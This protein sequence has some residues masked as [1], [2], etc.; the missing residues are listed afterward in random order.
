ML[1]LA[2]A[3]PSRAEWGDH[4]SLD[5]PYLPSQWP[6]EN[7]GQE[8]WPVGC[9]AGTS[10][11]YG[12]PGA[13]LEWGLAFDAGVTGAGAVIALGTPGGVASLYCED[14]DIAPR[15]WTNPGEIAGNGVDD[16]MNG[17][18]DDVNGWNFASNSGVV[19]RSGAPSGSAWHDTQVAQIAVGESGN[20]FGGAG[21]A[22][23][24]RILVVVWSADENNRVFYDQVLPYATARGA[25]VVLVPYTGYA[26]EPSGTQTPEQA[27][28][29]VAQAPPGTDRDAILASSAAVVIWGQPDRPTPGSTGYQY[30]ACDPSALGVV[31]S[32]QN[33]LSYALADSPFTDVALPGALPT[34]S[35]IASSW[36]MGHAAGV[37]ALVLEQSPWLTRSQLVDRLLD[38]AEK[39]GGYPY[40]GGRNDWYGEGRANAIRSLLLGDLDMDGVA[41]DGNGSGVTGDLPCAGSAVGCDDN[42]PFEPNAAQVDGGGVGG[43]GADGTGNACQ[44]GDVLGDGQ[45]LASDVA[46]VRDVLAG[47]SVPAADLSR[48]NV[49]GPAGPSTAECDVGDVAALQRALAGE[50]VSLA[51][52]CAPALP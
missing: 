38:G 35:S 28:T 41:G 34:G 48:C 5:D 6:L 32:N 4:L 52:Q 17:K 25:R 31:P 36:A 24:A 44:C 23:G 49:A 42:C 50:P 46:A 26:V 43:P 2:G 15:L 10:C 47:I 20:G 18:P 1:T 3:E 8:A 13:D 29:A 51:Q 40:V 39:I 11:V 33:D 12:T 16:D 19:C 21:V 9:V 22:S 30:P 45:V 37:L 27:C 14:P 7:T